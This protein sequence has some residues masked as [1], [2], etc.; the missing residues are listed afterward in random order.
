MA[1]KKENIWADQYNANYTSDPLTNW[2]PNQALESYSKV[3]WK[4]RE[5]AWNWRGTEHV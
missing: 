2:P 5:S 1:I 3:T 4:W